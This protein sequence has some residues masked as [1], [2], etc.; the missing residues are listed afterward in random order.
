ML[1][2]AKA[3]KMIKEDDIPPPVF[4]KGAKAASDE[5]KEAQQN[6]IKEACKSEVKAEVKAEGSNVELR[7]VEGLLYILSSS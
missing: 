1:K 2:D 6:E 7:A 5:P 4:V 3:G